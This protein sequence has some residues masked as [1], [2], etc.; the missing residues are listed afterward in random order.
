MT[1]TVRARWTAWGLCR[2]WYLALLIS[3]AHRVPVRKCQLDAGTGAGQNSL[4]QPTAAG[5]HGPQSGPGL[6]AQRV[7]TAGADLHQ[8]RQ[9]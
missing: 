1:L 6:Q 7:F 4:R 3:C 5:A 8:S 2:R 9:A